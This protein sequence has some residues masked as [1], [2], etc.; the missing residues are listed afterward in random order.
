MFFYQRNTERAAEELSELGD[1]I[2]LV[3]E[4]ELCATFPEL[5]RYAT[6]PVGESDGRH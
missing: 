5:A 1:E 4:E 2:Y 6:Q 3:L